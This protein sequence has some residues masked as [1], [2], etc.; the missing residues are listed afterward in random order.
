MQIEF[1][2]EIGLKT[3]LTLVNKA[4][5][6]NASEIKN[7]SNSFLCPRP[8]T[9]HSLCKRYTQLLFLQRSQRKY[10]FILKVPTVP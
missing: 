5:N 3:I 4:V 9:A 2:I 6:E 1:I 8:I 10:I 7:G